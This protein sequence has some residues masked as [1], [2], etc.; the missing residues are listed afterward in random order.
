MPTRNIVPRANG[1]GNI[2]TTNKKW[3]GIYANTVMAGNVEADTVTAG[4]VDVFFMLLKRNKAYKV[5]D[6]AYSPNLPSWARLECVV[7]GTTGR[8]EPAFSSIKNGGS[9]IND[10]TVRFIVDDIRDGNPVGT[11]LQSLCTRDGY[12]ALNGQ[13]VTTTSYPRLTKWVQDNNL[14]SGNAPFNISATNLTLPNYDGKFFQNSNDDV[15]RVVNAGLPNITGSQGVWV[16]KDKGAQPT[17]AFFGGVL[18]NNS[19]VQ[20][21]QAQN[22]DIVYSD[23]DA[24]RSNPIYGKSTTVQPPAVKLLTLIKY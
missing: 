21:V 11:I 18:V 12:L 24:S 1:E 20:Q 15:G 8:T 19:S 10:G 5:G 3:S 7:A 2:G 22:N 16:S 23:F 6:I 13:T 17:G 4:N 14:T 9:M